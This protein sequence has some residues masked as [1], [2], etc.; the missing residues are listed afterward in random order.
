MA[1]AYT[2]HLK[3]REGLY[4]DG[5]GYIFIIIGLLNIQRREVR[6]FTDILCSAPFASQI[7]DAFCYILTLS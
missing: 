3:S 5:C 7:L 2:L 1:R 6:S 4:F